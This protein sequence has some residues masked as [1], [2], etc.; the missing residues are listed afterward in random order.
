MTSLP[1]SDLPHEKKTVSANS[2]FQRQ[3]IRTMKVCEMGS[4]VLTPY[5]KRF[6]DVITKAVLSSELF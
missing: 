1:S 2:V 6:E 3:R 5:P 4:M